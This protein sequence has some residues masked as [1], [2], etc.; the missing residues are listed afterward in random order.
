MKHAE[1]NEDVVCCNYNSCFIGEL[2][3]IELT[4]RK[5]NRRR[6]LMY[7]VWAIGLLC[8]LV[9]EKVSPLYVVDLRDIDVASD[10]SVCAISKS[11]CAICKCVHIE[12]GLRLKS[13]SGS[14]FTNCACAISK[15]GRLANRAQRTCI[16]TVSQKKFPPSNSLQ[17][18]QILTDFQNFCTA[19]KRM[20]F[21]TKPMWQY[22]PHLKHVATLPWQIK[23]SNCPQIFSRYGRKCKQIAFLIAPN[24]AS[25][26]P[27]WLL[28]KEFQFTVVLFI[29]FC[30]QLVAPEIRHSRRHC[31]VSQQST[32]YE[33]TRTRF[34]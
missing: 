25:H 7:S 3:W 8:L 2:N 31:R 28:I 24:F 10:L 18:C 15:L 33:T 21:A 32:W 30:D 13:G 12:L 23:N 14:K 16:Y 20:K 6:F 5:E 27:Y 11:R 17:L 9:R 19:G 34:W 1:R 29:Y 26:F 4:L 22:P